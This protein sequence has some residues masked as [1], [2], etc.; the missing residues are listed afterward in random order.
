MSSQPAPYARYLDDADIL[1]V[2]LRDLPITSTGETNAWT[3]IDRAADGLVVAV[4]FVSV[5]TEGIDLN[6][7][8]ERE[9]V[10]RL[11]RD[12]GVR[13]PVGSVVTGT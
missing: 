13:L 5:R 7:I 2:R 11:I 3:N 10:A 6:G 4:E 1:Y 12:S 9:T 8:P